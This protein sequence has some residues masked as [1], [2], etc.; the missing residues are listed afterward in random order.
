MSIPRSTEELERLSNISVD[1][2]IPVKLYFRSAELILKQARVYKLENDLEH[3][4]LLYMKYTN[5]GLSELPKHP[6]YKK[7]ENKKNIK[8]LNKNCLEALEALESMKPQLNK[9]YKSYKEQIQRKSPIKSPP[10][11]DTLPE[12]EQTEKTSIEHI[13]QYSPSSP[14]LEALGDHLKEWNL[15]EALEGV[16]GVGY[17]NTTATDHSETSYSNHE[18]TDYP[19]L[20]K[21]NQSDQYNYQASYRTHQLISPPKLPPKIPHPQQPHYPTIPPKIPFAE[22]RP[23]LPPKIKISSGPTVD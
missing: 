20:N 11:E 22:N 21:H 16:Q 17:R 3:A 13:D 2:N 4:Y 8:T 5:L 6:A 10:P 12:K 9:I 23:E 14:P 18:K 1:H 19:S 15:Q 7:V